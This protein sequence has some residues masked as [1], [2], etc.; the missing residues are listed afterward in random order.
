MGSKKRNLKS[1]AS[2]GSELRFKDF[3]WWRRGIFLITKLV[4]TKK[5]NAIPTFFN[6][7]WISFRFLR[8]RSFCAFEMHFV[9]AQWGK[10]IWRWDEWCDIHFSRLQQKGFLHNYLAIKLRHCS[11]HKAKIKKT[12]FFNWH[13]CLICTFLLFYNDFLLL[14]CTSQCSSKLWNIVQMVQIRF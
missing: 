3:N 9:F 13:D 11:K 8:P 5:A 12:D 2:K 14:N 1:V 6:S 4:G 10:P 7:A